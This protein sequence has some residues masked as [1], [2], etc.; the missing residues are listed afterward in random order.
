MSRVSVNGWATIVSPT[1][2]TGAVPLRVIALY[3]LLFALPTCAPSA[4]TRTTCDRWRGSSPSSMLIVLRHPSGE[5][6]PEVVKSTRNARTVAQLIPSPCDIG[7][8]PRKIRRSSL[9][10]QEDVVVGLRVSENS[11]RTTTGAAQASNRV[12]HRNGM[13]RPVPCE[14]FAR[15]TVRIFPIRSSYPHDGES[16]SPPHTGEKQYG[17]QGGQV[18]CAAILQPVEQPILFCRR[19]ARPSAQHFS[20]QSACQATP[21]TSNSSAPR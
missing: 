21:A 15:P 2:P 7:H 14:V 3:P 17:Y 5:R 11:P 9:F 13:T 20:V 16:A 4:T 18:W 10:L 8:V 19:H 1:R 6:V 12:Q